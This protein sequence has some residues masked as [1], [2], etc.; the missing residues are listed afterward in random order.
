MALLCDEGHQVRGVYKGRDV[1]AAMRDFEPDAVLLDLGMPDLSG[2]EVARE[3]R[4]RYGYKHPVLIAISG[5][6]KQSAD[7]LLG[8][9]AGFDYHVD[10]PCEPGELISLLSKVTSPSP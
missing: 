2:W 10:K 6:Y 1:I 8:R 9:L 3:I 5:R 7:K 4:R